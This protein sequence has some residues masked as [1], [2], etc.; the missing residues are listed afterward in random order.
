MRDQELLVSL[1]FDTEDYVLP[2]SDDMALE[3]ARICTAAGVVATFKVVGEK[4]RMLERRG[5]KDVIDALAQHEIGYHTDLH[6]RPPSPAI[7]LQHAGWR[8]GVAEFI[9]RERAGLEDVRRIFDAP[10]MT[11]GQPGSSWAPQAFAGIRNLGVPTYLDESNHLSFDRLPFYFDGILTISGLKDRCARMELEEGGLDRA[12]RQFER[13]AGEVSDDGRGL[14]SIPYHPCEWVQTEFWDASNYRAGATVH[15]DALVHEPARPEQETAQYL[16]AFADYLE[17]LKSYPGV[18]FVT[19]AELTQI[20]ADTLAGRSFSQADVAGVAAAMTDEIE[21]VEFEGGWLSATDQL[22]LMVHA[23]SAEAGGE[24][25]VGTPLDGPDRAHRGSSGMERPAKVPGW[26]FAEAVGDVAHF[27]QSHAQ[28]PS[29]VWL[30]AASISPEDFLASLAPLVAAGSLSTAVAAA[31]PEWVELR[32]ARLASAAVVGE[33]SAEVWDW[34]ILPDGFR[35]EHL[36]ELARLQSW[37]FKPA[38]RG[39]LPGVA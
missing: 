7:Y 33:D 11:Y 23:V 5:R 1:W 13:I 3:L 2:A 31:T 19:V 30:G 21:P 27:M 10:V 35:S 16:S 22:D 34:P 12:K 36:L 26:L 8:D 28:V 18:R 25:R 4:A 37:T 17:F 24:L 6:S 39:S 29:Q 20:Y 14:I 32:Q 15:P 38:V 9:R